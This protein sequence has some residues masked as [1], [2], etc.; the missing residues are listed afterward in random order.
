RRH[1]RSK[2]DWSSDV[3]S[4]DLAAQAGSAFKP[5]VLATALEQGYG[6]NSRVDGRG[7][8]NIQGSRVQNAG[9]SPGGVM[10]LTQATQVSNNLGY[11]ELAQEVGFEEIRQTA[12][13]MGLPEGSIDDN[14]LVPVMPLGA[15]SVRPVDQASG[16]GTFANEGVH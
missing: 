8:R 13:D 11:I 6:L 4:S 2:R 16:F 7:P 5:Y 12:Y 3:C 14:Q 1:T 9:N 10:T 15:T